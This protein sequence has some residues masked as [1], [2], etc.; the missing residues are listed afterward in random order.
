MMKNLYLYIL[1]YATQSKKFVQDNREYLDALLDIWSGEDHEILK[2]ILNHVDLYSE[3]P[4]IHL[5]D[6]FH[7]K[8]NILER[9]DFLS[10][11][12]A[13]NGMGES[14]VRAKIRDYVVVKRI[15]ARLPYVAKLVNQEKLQE[16]VAEL[17]DLRKD[18][19]GFPGMDV[20]DE[21]SDLFQIF[22]NEYSEKA[23]GNKREMSY[24][25]E[26]LDVI[27]YR[28]T[29]NTVAGWLAEPATGKTSFGCKFA[30]NLIQTGRNVLY[31]NVEGDGPKIAARIVQIVTNINHGKREPYSQV[32][33]TRKGNGHIEKMSSYMVSPGTHL[34]SLSKD[35]ISRYKEKMNLLGKR[36]KV[37]TFPTSSLTMS[38]IDT[39]IESFVDDGWVPDVVILDHFKFLK[40]SD[41]QDVRKSE[42]DRYMQE[43][44]NV[45]SKYDLSFE[46]LHQPSQSG[47]VVGHGKMLT[48][49]EHASESKALW[50]PLSRACTMQTTPYEKQMGLTRFLVEKN[51]AVL[52]EALEGVVVLVASNF[53]KGVIGHGSCLW[54][55]GPVSETEVSSS[56]N[57]DF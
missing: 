50:Q 21:R 16:V 44:V 20:L 2:T 33:I 36:L 10:N 39:H 26:M 4:G 15:F 30:A 11:K 34:S 42:A 9:T 13:L 41:T 53:R 8:K 5:S 7:N 37:V 29:R 49:A 18:A 55:Q 32:E 48:W 12:E 19:F 45:A 28:P 35:Q 3:C 24:G 43:A 56:D 23:L 51:R 52:P 1:I 14:F 22:I 46:V 57:D 54:R 6:Y 40:F 17:D 31:I 38:A 27:G 25:I 47:G